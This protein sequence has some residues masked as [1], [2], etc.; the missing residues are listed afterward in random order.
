MKTI[1]RT[2]PSGNIPMIALPGKWDISTMHL[3]DNDN[4]NGT[5]SFPTIHKPGPAR[6]DLQT[7]PLHNVP[8]Q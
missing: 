3:A 6:A 1:P 8:L 4:W 7:W 5:S 2:G